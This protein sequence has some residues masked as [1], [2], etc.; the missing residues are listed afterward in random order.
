MRISRHAK[1]FLRRSKARLLIKDYFGALVDFV[2]LVLLSEHK[3]EEVDESLAKQIEEAHKSLTETETARLERE[4][5][6]Q[7]RFLPDD[8]F[9]ASYLSSFH[10]DD[11]ENDMHPV[12]SSDHYT[13]S[14][15]SQTDAT[16]DT[17]GELLTCRGLVHKKE[18][19]YAQASQDFSEACKIL[20]PGMKAYYTAQIESGLFHHLK[21][22]FETAKTC[23][24]AALEE[25]PNS[26][27]SFIRLGGLCFD[28]KDLPGALE[29]FQRAFS[30]KPDCPTAYFHR[31]QLRSIDVSLEQSA[32]AEGLQ[33]AISDLT[34]CIEL[35]SDFAMAY[36]QLGVLHTRV[37]AFE[38][39]TTY[40]KA[41]A[42]LIPDAPEAYNYLGE[43]YMQM[44]GDPQSTVS[45]EM[46]ENM[47]DKALEVDPTYPMA[48]INKG[49]ILAQ[50]NPA[51]AEDAL[52]LFK[53]A[54]EMS[55]RS[56]LAYVNLAQVYLAMQAYD[57]AIEQIDQAV[58]LVYTSQEY[59][60]LAALRVT[61]SA[62][63][64]ANKLLGR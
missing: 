39:G 1:S 59:S 23:F 6:G 28:R 36:M 25:K 29:W 49:S 24:E 54:I 4:N 18:R 41:A 40:L 62:H 21:G 46:V 56:K 35:A 38:V 3:N 55:P 45:L 33:E 60:E 51:N 44:L 31:G 26:L 37:G 17:L 13:E 42:E 57:L 34:R 22:D 64:E 47:F 20:K 43:I 52:G 50:K 5:S 11:D 2:C 48:Y 63:A 8:Y 61:A 16:A 19:K 58:K 10:P 9:I 32:T 27:F 14:I 12:K 7:E 53:K 30:I 15:S